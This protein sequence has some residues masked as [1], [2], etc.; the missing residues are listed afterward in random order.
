[1]ATGTKKQLT[2]RGLAALQVGE[3]AND[4][5]PHGAG[6]LQARKLSTGDIGFYYRYTGPDRKQVRVPLGTGLSLAEAREQATVLSRRYQ[7]GERD[8]RAALLAEDREAE[9]RR[10]AAEAALLAEQA[11]VAGTLG[12]L[13]AGYVEDLKRAGKTSARAVDRALRL[14]VE[15]PWPK[16][17]ATPA[18]E[19]SIDDLLAV[20]ARLADAGKL[21]EAAKLRAYLRAA[22]SAAVKARKSAHALPALRELQISVNPARDL[23]P[24]D[25]ATAPRERALSVAELRAYWQRIGQLEAPDG[26]LLRF[27]LLTGVQRAEQLGR[28]TVADYDRDEQTVRLRDTKG[29]RRQPREHIVPLTEP[30]QQALREMRGGEAGPNLFTV[31][32]G[33]SPAVYATVQ[34]R[35]RAVAT[36]MLDAGE[37]EQGLFTPGDLRRT[38]E[39]RLAAAGVSR[40]AHA[41]LQSHG[42]GGVQERHYDKTCPRS[43][44]RLRCSGGCST[45]RLRR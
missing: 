45:A 40:E 11:R 43:A 31:T 35:V 20:V 10:I 34:H 33:H 26:P 32:A 39:T 37:L 5:K 1:M 9:R 28:M 23:T 18:A 8:L 3:W 36:A 29:R 13:L 24:I 14:H 6:Q 30:A 4:G 2:P 44:R 21:R 38:V 42:L 25:G 15:A 7:A 41:Q 16:L 17:W 12:V 19:V 27:H 22:Y